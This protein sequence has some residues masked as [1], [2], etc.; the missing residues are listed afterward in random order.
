[1]KINQHYPPY[2]QCTKVNYLIISTE[3]KIAFDRIKQPSMINTLSKLE[4][5]GRETFKMVEE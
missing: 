5:E 3:T 2:K 4:I 1:M